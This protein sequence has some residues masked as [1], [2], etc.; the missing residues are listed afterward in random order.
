MKSNF[1]EWLDQDNICQNNTSSSAISADEN[2]SSDDNHVNEES[3]NP[4]GQMESDAAADRSDNADGRNQGLSI[5]A[6]IAML[7]KLM[8]DPDAVR[9]LKMLAGMNQ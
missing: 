8:K 1:D 4:V 6:D 5:S 2:G 9:I 7:I 3:D